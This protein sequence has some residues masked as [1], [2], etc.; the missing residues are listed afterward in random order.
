MSASEPA[1]E[2]PNPNERERRDRLWN[3]LLARSERHGVEPGLL[4]E[5]QLYGGAQGIWVHKTITAGEQTPYG[6]A[7][8]VLHT[9]RSYADDL[10]VDGVVYHYPATARPPRRDAVEVEALK[11]ACLQR[12]P[13]FVITPGTPARLRKVVRGFVTE[14][15]DQ[16]RQCL[17]L[18]GDN[19]PRPLPQEDEAFKLWQPRGRKITVGS[20]P[21][22]SPVF[23]FRVI[24]RYGARCAVCDITA[25]AVIDA[26]H[27][28]PV[29]DEGSDD[30]RNG[31]PLCATH[32]RAFDAGLFGLEP[33]SL[34]IVTAEGGPSLHDLR[35][36]RDDLT[37]LR[38]L[39]HP[40][41]VAWRWT[42][43]SPKTG[44][45]PGANALD[46]DGA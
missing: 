4:R 8:S 5:L 32:H 41:A 27:L 16:A 33:G 13:V 17:I 30:A 35:I 24:R 25:T 43:K 7:V 38:A 2:M 9:G 28:C 44:P 19:P 12:L 15:N 39:P 34:R 6:I 31:L 21:A 11:A 22:R 42:H 14:F 23:Q 3:A 36:T 37:H 18:F 29:D 10:T 40:E 1:I 26:A 20:R 46:D 45:A